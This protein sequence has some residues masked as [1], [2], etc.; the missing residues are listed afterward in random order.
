VSMRAKL[1]RELNP[2]QKYRTAFEDRGGLEP[3]S[4]TLIVGGDD[5]IG[6]R[7]KSASRSGRQPDQRMSC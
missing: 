2:M 7:L 3:I 1:S 4:P 5:H 6:D